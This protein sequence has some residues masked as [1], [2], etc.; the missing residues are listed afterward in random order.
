MGDLNCSESGPMSELGSFA[1]FL[2]SQRVRF[3][4]RAERRKEERWVRAEIDVLH[5]IQMG[6]QLGP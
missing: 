1:S 6:S 2:P 3:V 5:L 4:P